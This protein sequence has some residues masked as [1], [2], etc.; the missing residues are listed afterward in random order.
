MKKTGSIRVEVRGPMADGGYWCKVPPGFPEC[1]IPAKYIT[2]IREEVDW[3]E[4]EKGTPMVQI[5][6]TVDD[7][8]I[9]FFAKCLK[10]EIGYSPS[11]IEAKRGNWKYFAPA[12]KC[13]LLTDWLKE[14]GGQDG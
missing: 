8:F 1:P 6:T 2:D 5:E 11:Y 9:W 12:R 7:A 4:V 14:H 3:S 13:M 10:G